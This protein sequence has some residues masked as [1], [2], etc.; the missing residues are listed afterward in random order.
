MTDVR[1]YMRKCHERGHEPPA[2]GNCV[3]CRRHTSQAIKYLET[4][5]EDKD[6]R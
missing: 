4:Y 3:E 2:S 5:E 6:A 1:A